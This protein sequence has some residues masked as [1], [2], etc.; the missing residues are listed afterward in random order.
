MLLHHRLNSFLHI[1][2]SQSLQIRFHSSVKNL[3]R[4]ILKEHG[5]P[6]CDTGSY[7]TF[8]SSKVIMDENVPKSLRDAH[9]IGSEMYADFVKTCFTDIQRPSQELFLKWNQYF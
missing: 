7:L 5:N 2:V 4:I 3:V 1:E 8:L 6:F 9:D